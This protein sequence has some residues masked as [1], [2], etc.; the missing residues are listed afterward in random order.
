M[1]LLAT[2]SLLGVAAGGPVQDTLRV[3]TL[4]AAA[5]DRDPRGRELE[6]LESQTALVCRA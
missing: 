1:I 3:E 2:L 4:T 6:L 5:R